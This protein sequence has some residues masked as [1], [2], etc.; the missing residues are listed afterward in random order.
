MK[1]LVISDTHGS[2]DHAAGVI[3]AI[4]DKISAI[5]HLG[6]HD[7]DAQKIQDWY[8]KIPVHCVAGNCDFGS[9]S[10]KEQV[11]TF[12]HK[13]IWITHGHNHHVKWGYDTISY[14]GSEKGVDAVLFGHTHTPLLIQ[15]GSMIL[16]NPGSIS[17]P[18]GTPNPTYGMI[19][20]ND[21]GNMGFSIVSVQPNDLY[22][23]IMNL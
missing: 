23:P 10:P 4:K 16:M 2:L 22:K 9:Q 21:Q 1:L 20:I 19:D 8:P 3:A 14:A 11:L 18:R 5:I 7:R 12:V 15:I 13:K 17:N 6:D